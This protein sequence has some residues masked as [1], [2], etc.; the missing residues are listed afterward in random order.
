MR[1]AQH[2]HTQPITGRLQQ[3]ARATICIKDIDILIGRTMFCD[4]LLDQG[5]DFFGGI[6]QNC[7][8]AF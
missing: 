6:V 2:F 4:L 5:G 3:T 1:P 8:Q 7:G